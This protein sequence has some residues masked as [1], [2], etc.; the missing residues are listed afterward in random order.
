[1]NN[2]NTFS[3]I[4]ALL[5]AIHFANKY[6]QQGSETIFQRCNIFYTMLGL[7]TT[8]FSLGQFFILTFV[9]Q[10]YKICTFLTFNF[11]L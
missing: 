10:N 9:T 7:L 8:A 11:L 5:Q 4:Y 6:S 1:M 2:I 3:Y